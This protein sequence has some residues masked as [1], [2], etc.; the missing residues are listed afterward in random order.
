V[1]PSWASFTAA[2]DDYERPSSHFINITHGLWTAGPLESE[3]PRWYEELKLAELAVLL[4]ALMNAD[5]F[6][7]PAERVPDF[8]GISADTFERGARGLQ[9]RGLLKVS[10]SRKAAPLAPEGYTV[11]NRY[12]L[13]PPFGSMGKMGLATGAVQ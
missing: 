4:I 5:D 10:H 3:G 12:T 13:C 11:E 6:A 7:L 1:R 9:N 8:Y 2:D